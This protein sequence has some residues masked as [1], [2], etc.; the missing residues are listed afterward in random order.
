LWTSDPSN[1]YSATLQDPS[2]GKS[3]NQWWTSV[4]VPRGVVVMAQNYAGY[5]SSYTIDRLCQL[6]QDPL[7]VGSNCSKSSY[8]VTTGSDQTAG[9]QGLNS[10][11]QV[12]YRITIRIDGPRNTLSYIQTIVS[13]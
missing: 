4:A 3:W 6:A 5:T 10:V 1:G 2:P 11:S 9:S 7:A 8:Q 12:Y 13:L